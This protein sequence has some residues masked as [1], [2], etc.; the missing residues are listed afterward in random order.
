M[1]IIYKLSYIF[2]FAAFLTSCEEEVV[3]YDTNGGKEAYLFTQE[4]SD[5]P[6]GVDG[7]SSVMVEVGATTKSNSDRVIPITIDPSSTATPDQYSINAASLV[8]PAGEF[9]GHV[10]IIGNFDAVPDGAAPTLVLNLD[11]TGIDIVAD[12]DQ[13]VVNIFRFCP[14][15]LAGEYSVTTTYS[16][17]DFLPDFPSYTMNTTIEAQAGENT[18]KVADFS[19]GLYSVGPYA[20]AYGTGAPSAATA[21]DL[22]FTINCARVTWAGQADPWGAIIP[23]QGAVNSYDPETGVITISW[24]AVGYGETGVSVYTPI[25]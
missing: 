5:L 6:I 16:V 17:H 25:N 10:E 9:V 1:K 4:E 24:T 2:F 19:G 7:A 15:D 13:H 14:T 18:Y 22:I 3:K 23:T 11:T 20:E 12:K 21:I 8:I